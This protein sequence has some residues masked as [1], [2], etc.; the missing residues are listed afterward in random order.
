[1]IIIVTFVSNCSIISVDDCC[2][3]CFFRVTV[4][5]FKVILYNLCDDDDLWLVDG[6]C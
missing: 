6:V 3:I 1:M 2:L 5:I 4:D